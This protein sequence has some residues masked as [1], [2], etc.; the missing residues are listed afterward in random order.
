[1]RNP[2]VRGLKRQL[3]AQLLFGFVAQSAYEDFHASHIVACWLMTEREHDIVF[4]HSG[5][6]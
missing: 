6:R 2:P 4:R 5:P 3:G 1:M